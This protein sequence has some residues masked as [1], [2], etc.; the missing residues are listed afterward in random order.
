MKRPYLK[1]LLEKGLVGGSRWL[2]HSNLGTVKN[3]NKKYVEFDTL[4]DMDQFLTM[5]VQN[6]HK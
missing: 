1:K 6:S 2:K 3:K 5:Q 4:H